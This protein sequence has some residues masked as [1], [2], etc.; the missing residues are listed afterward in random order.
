VPDYWES[1]IFILSTDFKRLPKL[2]HLAL[3]VYAVAVT[4]ER[5]TVQ[6]P[7]SLE[8]V[9][10]ELHPSWD[11]LANDRR[12]ELR[13]SWFRDFLNSDEAQIIRQELGLDEEAIPIN[14]VNRESLTICRPD[15]A[16]RIAG[17]SED[18]LRQIAH[19]V[20]DAQELVYQSSVSE[21]LTHFF[22]LPEPDDLDDTT[23]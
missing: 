18:E 3:I 9:M 4:P 20:A 2:I 14:W 10:R 8:G 21:V 22:G 1:H 12:N 11:E 19:D 23:P 13:V 15:L 17:L 7:P 16:D 6:P 5:G